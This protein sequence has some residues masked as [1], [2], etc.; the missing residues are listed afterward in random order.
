MTPRIRTSEIIGLTL[1][2]CKAVLD[3]IG[4]QHMI[5]DVVTHMAERDEP[6]RNSTTPVLP[7]EPM[8][9]GDALQPLFDPPIPAPEEFLRDE[10]W[11]AAPDTA[12]GQI[13]MLWLRYNQTAIALAVACKAIAAL[14]KRV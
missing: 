4:T 5:K 14:E 12:E 10:W 6:K 3:V 9:L 11:K 2:L 7:E 1:N 13:K 8:S